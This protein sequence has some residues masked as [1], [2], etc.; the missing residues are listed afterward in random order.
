MPPH[1][2]Q[3]DGRNDN[4]PE[5]T[6]SHNWLPNNCECFYRVDAESTLSGHEFT[7][8]NDRGESVSRPCARRGV[9]RGLWQCGSC[10]DTHIVLVCDVCREHHDED[11]SSAIGARIVWTPAQ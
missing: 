10:P 1:E 6:E 4:H 3:M 9:W 7:P 2:E 8:F 11:S 5:W